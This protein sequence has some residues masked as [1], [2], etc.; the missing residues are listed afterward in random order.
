MEIQEFV[1]ELKKR[2]SQHSAPNVRESL[3]EVAGAFQ[4]VIDDEKARFSESPITGIKG[5][6]SSLSRELSRK[7]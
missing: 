2:A 6:L 3:N 4:L 7:K 1:D 5:E